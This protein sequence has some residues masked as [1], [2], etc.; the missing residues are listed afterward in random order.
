MTGN[1][2]GIGWGG[3]GSWGTH[4][5]KGQLQLWQVV[6]SRKDQL[7]KISVDAVLAVGARDLLFY[8]W[9]LVFPQKG[10]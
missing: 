9:E 3:G 5:I 6:S 4:E 2:R 8:R 1:L 10:A 7:A